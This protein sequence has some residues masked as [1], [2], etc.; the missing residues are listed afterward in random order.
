MSTQTNISN[1]GRDFL[2]KEFYQL[3]LDIVVDV[4]FFIGMTI[5]ILSGLPLSEEECA[6]AGIQFDIE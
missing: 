6:Q 2:K 5:A 1:V 4:L 3:R